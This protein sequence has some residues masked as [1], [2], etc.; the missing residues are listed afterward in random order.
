MP[1]LSPMSQDKQAKVKSLPVKVGRKIK[2][3]FHHTH[4]HKAPET[5]PFLVTAATWAS[6]VFPSLHVVREIAPI[7]PKSEYIKHTFVPTDFGDSD[8]GSSRRTAITSERSSQ[9][10][11]SSIA[12]IPDDFSHTQDASFATAMS[13]LSIGMDSGEAP[14]LEPVENLI[15]SPQ[16]EERLPTSSHSTPSS[17]HASYREPEVPSLINEEDDPTNNDE[18]VRA[19]GPVSG[20]QQTHEISLTSEPIPSY[21]TV[22]FSNLNKDV[23]PLPVPS[24]QS[25]EDETL[26]LYF[27]GLIMPTM[28]LPIPNVRHFSSTYLTW[29]LS[30]SLMYYTRTRRIR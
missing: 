1:S 14:E 16:A 28:F 20:S 25:P 30:R 8:T 19:V 4:K 13:S 18:D 22:P 26:D 7:Y 6:P 29:W 5:L 23:P 10:S 27:P 11:S 3:L 15:S 21:P 24:S 17:P 9:S 12:E 2:G